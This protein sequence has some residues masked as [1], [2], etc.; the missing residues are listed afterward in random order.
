MD[1]LQNILVDMAGK[2]RRYSY[3]FS[4][5]VALLIIFLNS[6]LGIFKYK[7]TPDFVNN[8]I[9]ISGI[10]SGY[11]L[12]TYG[13]FVSLGNNNF[14]K[15]LHQSGHFKIVYKIIMFGI[16][17]LIISMLLG[18]FGISDRLMVI[19]FL[20]GISEVILSVYYFY[21][22]TLLSSKSN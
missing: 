2:I 14:I 9:N 5:A 19:S 4:P 20:M 10:L 3:L 16:V 13:I 8:I 11:L 15:Y 17:F 21:M 22:L 7:I 1:S 6:K 18:L 12:T